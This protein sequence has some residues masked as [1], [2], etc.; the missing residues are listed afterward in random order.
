MDRGN[1][2]SHHFDVK[3]VGNIFIT[4]CTKCGSTKPVSTEVLT[5]TATVPNNNTILSSTNVRDN[6]AQRRNST[7]ITSEGTKRVL[8]TLFA[9]YENQEVHENCIISYIVYEFRK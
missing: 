8:G 3:I 9:G 1:E 6:L 4:V 7:P 2:C 5:A